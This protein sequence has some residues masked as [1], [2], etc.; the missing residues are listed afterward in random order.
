MENVWVLASVW[1]GLALVATLVAIWFKISA[2][3][4][5]L[6]V[7][8]VAQLVIGA[9]FVHT[10]LHPAEH[11]IHRAAVGG[12]DLIVLGRR[13]RSIT[14]QCAYLRARSETEPNIILEIMSEPTVAS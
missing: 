12:I 4:S 1:V 3:L 6:V 8:T 14:G 5:E 11:F 7:G 9:L 10:E 2:A 13:G